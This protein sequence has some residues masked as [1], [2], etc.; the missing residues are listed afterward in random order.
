V[1]RNQF[2][3]GAAYDGSNI[4]FTQMTELG[5]LN[6]DRSVTGIGAFG[7]GVTGGEADGEPYDTRV[8]LSSRVHSG[9]LYAT[10]ALTFSD[11]V[12]LTFSGRFNRTTIDNQD[13]IRPQAGTGSLTGK[14][15]FRRFNP[16]TGATWK[17]SGPVSL[18][19]SYTEGSRAPTA[20]ELGCADPNAP[21]KLPNAMAGD[22][23]LEQVVT[24]TLEAGVRGSGE[25]SLRW[26]AG[27]FHAV[28][29]DD[30]LFVASEQTGYGYFK[31]FDKTRRQG[32][33]LEASGRLGRMTLGGSYVLLDATFQSEEAVNGTGNSTNEEAQEGTPGTE[34]AIEIEPGN[35]IPLTPRHIA[36]A[37]ADVQVTPKLLVDLGVVGTSSSF[38][39]GN[40]NN[41]HAPDGSYYL[42][43]GSSPGYAVVNLGV[44]YNLLSRI[45]VFLQV[46]NLFDKQYYSGAQLGPTGFT[47]EGSFIARPFPAI[48]GEFPVQ[49]ATF[50]APG[51][52]RG[53]WA[54]LRFWF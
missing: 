9:S 32:M 54:G 37:W 6:P 19:G 17:I 23:P 40:E 28:N 39:R 51:A 53:A 36:K 21:C 29:R 44:R 14:H 31:N 47:A 42:G 22:P 2:T 13:L 49:G 10:D 25:K 26:S 52:P 1:R 8:N 45:Q 33:E 12:T 4:D 43:E 7:D 15:T 18:Y 46:N 27:W 11:N 3:A 24:R 41:L 38:A 16:A 20:I 50:Y 5:Y 48:N 35:R 30:I 34:G